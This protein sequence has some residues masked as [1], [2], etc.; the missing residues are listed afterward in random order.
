[1]K[2]RDR[3]RK[4]LRNGGRAGEGEQAERVGRRSERG[5]KKQDREEGIG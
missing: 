1:M 4:G 2:V 3:G 5:A